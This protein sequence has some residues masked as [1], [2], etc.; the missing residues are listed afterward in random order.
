MELSLLAAGGI[1]AI[2][3]TNFG[4]GLWCLA[5]PQISLVSMFFLFLGA[6]VAAAGPLHWGWL[7]LTVVGIFYI[8][9][10]K[11]A[12]GEIF[13]SGAVPSVPPEHLTPFSCG[14]RV[15]VEGLLPCGQTIGIVVVAHLFGIV[16][17]MVIVVYCEPMALWLGMIGIGAAYFYNG[18]PLCSGRWRGFADRQLT[19][20]AILA[21]LEIRNSGAGAPCPEGEKAD[22]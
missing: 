14:K 15:L 19:P 21:T 6:C 2:K 16:I 12:S 13:D 22:R 11:N 20:P 5:D 3:G 18:A 1:G 17:G 10:A 8:E 9:V 4:W 7:T